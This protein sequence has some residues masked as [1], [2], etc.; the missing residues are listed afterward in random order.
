[1]S[2]ICMS[3]TQH[4]SSTSCRSNSQFLLN[5][6]STAFTKL[7]P[8]RAQFT[9]LFIV[10]F[11]LFIIPNLV[12]SIKLLPDDGSTDDNFGYS[13][14]LSNDYAV[15]GAY[16]NSGSGCA[17]VFERNYL[18]HWNQTA[19]L[20]PHDGATDDFF[21]YSVAIFNNYAVIGAYND[22]DKGAQS[23]SAYIYERD[24]FGGWNRTA[25]L[26]PVDGA[27]DD[28]FGRSVAVSTNYTAIG[29]HRDDGIGANSGSVYIFERDTE[30]QW[31][32]TAKLVADDE[33]ADDNFGVSV[34]ARNNYLVIG[35]P[36]DLYNS[37]SS[38]IF[39]RNE[40]GQWN[41]TAKLRPV[42]L[43]TDDQ[44]GMH[45]AASDDYIVIGSHGDDDKGGGS[46]SAYIFKRNGRTWTQMSKI[47]AGDAAV[48]NYFGIVAVSDTYVVVA[49]PTD[50]PTHA[51]TQL[52]SDP[53]HGVLVVKL[54]PL[55]SLSRMIWENGIKH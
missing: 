26:V 11:I 24:S 37:G 40:S 14:A 10:T 30:G 6:A 18:G 43:T 16:G 51:P 1:M 13:V 34:A 46:G 41:Q 15:I 7:N 52:T 25:K 22:D 27:A 33:A 19:K 5:V 39:Q 2:N 28:R 21:G 53:V 31:S 20:L 12:Q 44:F 50:D 4:R 36:G 54:E 47:F 55:I 42:D 3:H 17:Y 45:V 8:Y 49:I 32:Q 23:G 9:S 35:A 38:Y 48:G 29:A